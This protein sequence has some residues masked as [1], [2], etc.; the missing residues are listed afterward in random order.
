M[1]VVPAQTDFR[2]GQ[3]YHFPA[4]NSGKATHELAIEPADAAASRAA[5]AELGFTVAED[6]RPTRFVARDDRDRRVDFHYEPDATDRHDMRLL[7]GRLG[8]SLPGPY[9]RRF[10]NL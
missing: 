7:A 9:A 6:E 8:L 2:V 4:T 5:L 3:T 1:A 10:R